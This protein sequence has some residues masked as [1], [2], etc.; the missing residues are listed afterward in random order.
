MNEKHKHNFHILKSLAASDERKARM[1]EALLT[2][3]DENPV[4][5]PQSTFAVSAFMT[6]RRFSVYG[7]LVAVIVVF[8]GGVTLAAEGSM[9]GD[10][11]Y[12]VK[13]SVTEPIMT[14]LATSDE[15]K[16]RV[17]ST[18]AV[19][20]IDEIA[21]LASSGKLTD[22]Q[23]TKLEQAFDQ[24]VQVVDEHT[25]ALA[26]S[27]DAQTALSLQQQFSSSIASEAQAVSALDGRASPRTKDFIGKV[28]ALSA[29]HA[30]A[31][32]ALAEEN[33]EASAA[34]IISSTTPAARHTA[35]KE[36]EFK[37][38]ALQVTASTTLSNIIEASVQVQLPQD[39]ALQG[40]ER[41]DEDESSVHDLK[42][43]SF[44]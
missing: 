4:A 37:P 8:G 21:A 39:R 11:F 15:A 14:A 2:Y 13:V 7:T 26:K 34:A 42:I 12:G 1:R 44:R 41:E 17:A 35:E 20:R 40:G 38:R 29:R 36:G 23:Q 24:S 22:E 33:G 43:E 19:R 30:G 10:A 6:S 28:I 18:L 9:P 5:V 27:G 3:A 25:A 16:V 31:G 32:E